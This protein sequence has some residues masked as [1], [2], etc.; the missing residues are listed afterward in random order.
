MKRASTTR[1]SKLTRRPDAPD[2][3]VGP[4]GPITH[5]THNTQ[6]GPLAIAPGSPEP[7]AAYFWLGR[8][9]GLVILARF[10]GT[11]DP[12]RTGPTPVRTGIPPVVSELCAASMQGKKCNTRK[13]I[14][15]QGFGCLLS[16]ATFLGVSCLHCRACLCMH[17]YQ[18]ILPSGVPPKPLLSQHSSRDVARRAALEKLPMQGIGPGC[19][20]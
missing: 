14:L 13:L 2:A 5:W 8:W 20:C 17:S 10:G 11:P 16:L 15:R 12:Q 7:S 19:Q 9:P 1:Q 18:P 3:P 4:D 6:Q